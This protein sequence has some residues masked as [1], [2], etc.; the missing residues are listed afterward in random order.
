MERIRK[1]LRALRFDDPP[2]DFELLETEH[3]QPGFFGGWRDMRV[4]EPEEDGPVAPSVAQEEARWKKACRGAINPDLILRRFHI[5]GRVK[6]MAVFVNGMADG[7]AIAEF[8]LR[9]AMREG[10]LEGAEGELAAFCVQ[11]VFTMQEAVLVESRRDL[12]RAVL[13]GQTAV[14]IEGCTRAVV[15]D[16]R[17]FPSRSVG[18]PQNEVVILGPHEA[19]TENIRTNVSLLRRIIKTDDFVCEFRA[20]GGRNNNRIAIAYRQGVANRSLVHEVK[21]RFASVDTLMVLSI[22]TLEQL[23][24]KNSFAPVPQ[25][26]S[27]ER[28]D[29]VAAHIMQGRVAVLLE[30]SPLVSVVPATLFMLMSSGEDAYLRQP[31]GTVIRLVRYIGAFLSVIMPAYF[32]ALALHHQGMLSGEVLATVI[33]SRNMVFLPLG[34]EMLFLL[35]VFQLVREAGLALP[36]AMGQSIG[37][38]GGL[39]LGQAAVSANIVSQFVLITV[40]LTGLGNFAIPDYN[41]Q[42]AAV[43]YRIFLLLLAW[44]GGLLGLAC[45]LVLTVAYM[46]SLKSYGVPFL[47]PISPK[48]HS[49]G[50]WILRGVV[51]DSRR[52]SDVNNTEARA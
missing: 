13:E 33:A 21:R 32:L 37:I 10:C 36:G 30:G 41:L 31:I 52:P 50:S 2:S 42:L 38:I 11:H 14:Y 49:K 35:V 9:P 20:S 29:R 24:E 51:R 8:I 5:G 15:M 39:I 23:T 1:K 22:G 17:G 12:Q 44:I 48:T 18:T 43:Y 25:S 45:A 6:A 34:A 7:D 3:G 26:L 46:A 40:A 28:P 16:T 19:F 27:T 47:A 4:E